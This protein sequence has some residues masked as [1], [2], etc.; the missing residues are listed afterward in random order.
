MDYFYGGTRKGPSKAEDKSWMLRSAS[1]E[2]PRCQYIKS[3]SGVQCIESRT[4]RLRTHSAGPRTDRRFLPNS[5]REIGDTVA[6]TNLGHGVV[7]YLPVFIP[8]GLYTF[9]LYLRQGKPYTPPDKG[10]TEVKF[11]FKPKSMISMID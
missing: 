2:G 8:D 3:I 10:N 7:L 5:M 6:D 9:V 11:Y 1:T 4:F